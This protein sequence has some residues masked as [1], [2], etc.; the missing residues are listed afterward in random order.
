M[1][2]AKGGIFVELMEGSSVND[3]PFDFFKNFVVVFYNFFQLIFE[4]LLN[5]VIQKLSDIFDDLIKADFVFA[6]A[7]VYC[8][9]FEESNKAFDK[10]L[11]C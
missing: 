8:L 1:N 7:F 2:L 3:T 9:V 5:Q 10:I 11:I 4:L 6:D